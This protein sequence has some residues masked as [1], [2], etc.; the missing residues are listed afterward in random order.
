LP[1]AGNENE[2][3]AVLAR[4]GI[5]SGSQSCVRSLGNAKFPGKIPTIVRFRPLS[6]TDLPR[7]AG[8]APKF[9]FQR[10]SPMTVVS[11][12]LVFRREQLSAYWPRGECGED[13]S[14]H[15]T[16]PHA[17]RLAGAGETDTS[18]AIG[19]EMRQRLVLRFEIG[20]VRIGM[21]VFV[22]AEPAVVHPDHHHAI[23]FGIWQRLE[24]DRVNDAEDGRRCADAERDRRHCDGGERL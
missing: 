23:R 20:E 8:S 6:S 9:V 14:G 2:L 5:T 7:I 1:I 19:R 11:R 22:D 18:L 21:N 13:F 4:S 24:D 10:P 3:R 16:S 15:V 17:L 12:L